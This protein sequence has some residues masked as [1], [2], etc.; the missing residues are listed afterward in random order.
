M[1]PKDVRSRRLALGL[2]VEELAKALRLRMTDLREIENGERAVADAALFERTFARL[3]QERD[4]ADTY[5]QRIFAYNRIVRASTARIRES[6][7][8]RHPRAAGADNGGKRTHVGI[9]RN[10]TGETAKAC[11]PADSRRSLESVVA[12]A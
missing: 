5:K 11:L 4:T 10:V 1:T 2:T 8:R 7:V 9:F 3:E 6:T 12:C